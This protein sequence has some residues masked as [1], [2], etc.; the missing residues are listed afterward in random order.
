M[1]LGLE[2]DVTLDVGPGAKPEALPSYTTHPIRQI[3][4][5]LKTKHSSVLMHLMWMALASSLC[6]RDR[7]WG[8]IAHP[9]GR[10]MRFPWRLL[11]Y[12]SNSPAMETPL[13]ELH[14]CPNC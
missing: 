6:C 4:L 10:A 5:L 11:R 7:C 13:A 14:H 12:L 1:R 9:P 8:Y 3:P 2:P